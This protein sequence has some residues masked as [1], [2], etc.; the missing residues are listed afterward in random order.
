MRL[1]KRLRSYIPLFQINPAN[2]IYANRRVN[3]LTPIYIFAHVFAANNWEMIVNELFQSVN[4]SGLGDVYD[5]LF[6]TLSGTDKDLKRITEIATQNQIEAE[7]VFVSEDP[8]VYE[9]PALEFMHKLAQQKDFFALYF[10][11]KGAGNSHDSVKGYWPNITSYDQ[12][13][14]V[15][16]QWRQLMSY[17]TIEQYKLALNTLADGYDCYGALFT[18]QPPYRYY[19]GNFWW[20]TSQYLCTL[21]AFSVQ[22]KTYRYNAETWLLSNPNCKYYNTCSA[23]RTHSFIGIPAITYSSNIIKRVVGQIIFTKRFIFLKLKTPMVERYTS[24]PT[25]Q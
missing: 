4:S 20:T 5:K 19:A 7:I 2:K 13:V 25:L 17:W 24:K 11:S 1:F 3:K 22:D 8:K 6:I 10:H 12:L 23:P 15:S 9:F 14:S 16:T 18:L 21:P